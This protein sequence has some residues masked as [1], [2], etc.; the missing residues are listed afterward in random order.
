M[1]AAQ[2]IFMQ[3]TAIVHGDHICQVLLGLPDYDKI[4]ITFIL[5]N[6]EIMIFWHDFSLTGNKVDMQKKLKQVTGNVKLDSTW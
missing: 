4:V 1:C 3:V 5:P 6:V 2:K